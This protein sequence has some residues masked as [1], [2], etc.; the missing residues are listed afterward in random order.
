[1]KGIY[2]TKRKTG[3]FENPRQTKILLTIEESC[4][5]DDYIDNHA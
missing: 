1:M 3:D 5:C 4:H 2:H